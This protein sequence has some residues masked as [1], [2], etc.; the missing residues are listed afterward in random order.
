LLGKLVSLCL[1]LDLG[2]EGEATKI[3]DIKFDHEDLPYYLWEGTRSGGE[4]ST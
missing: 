4:N 2:I 1:C 3:K